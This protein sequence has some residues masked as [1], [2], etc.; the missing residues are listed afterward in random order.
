M[1]SPTLSRCSVNAR[2]LDQCRTGFALLA[3]LLITGLIFG[4]VSAT[5]Q[6]PSPPAPATN[7]SGQ[8]AAEEQDAPAADAKAPADAPPPSDAKEKPA[9]AADSQD[10]QA[11]LDEAMI[12]RIDADTPKQL[13]AVIALL[14]S[15]LVKGLSEESQSFANKMIASIQLERAQALA[16][17]LIQGGGLR[18]RTLRAE[19]LQTLKAAVKSDPELVEA[20]LLIARLHLLP[21]G[22]AE[23]VRKATTKAIELLED[24][25]QAQ[26]G[27]YLLRALRQVDDESRAAD[28]DRAVKTDPANA[29][30][31]QARALLR[32]QNE[33]VTGAVDDLKALLKQDPTNQAVAQVAV[34]E[35]VNMNRTEDALTLLNETLQANPSEGLYRLRGI[36]HRAEGKEDEALADFGKALAMQPKDPVSLLQRAEIS[37]GRGDVQ[38]AKRDL[39]EAIRVEPRVADS[40]AAVRVR[41]YIALE[42]GRIA[43]AIHDMNLIVQAS[44]ED[45]FWT[46]Q[47][48]NLYLQDK[49]PRKAIELVT[50]ILQRDPKNVSALRTRADTLLGLGDHAAAIKDYETALKIGIEEPLQRS[51]VLNNLAWVLA[52]SPKDDLRDG[53]RSIELGTEAAELTDFKEPHILSTLAAGYAEHGDFEEAIKWSS[54]AVQLGREQE[55][56]QIEQLEEEL[57][58]YR[59]NKPWREEQETEENQAP[60]LG[61]DDLIDT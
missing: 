13:E 20:Y 2:N 59:E 31:R 4:T 21:E 1:T 11:D 25:P 49:R 6:E 48:A 42:E 15:A 44:P 34:Q 39:N 40:V 29:E 35:L 17:Q 45:P 57:N 24:N 38:A 53:K 10:G 50:G 43:D 37:L 54:K 8:D 12:R 3:Y 16:A 41:C 30:A 14:E 55:H 60:L 22:D 61:P 56:D 51:G 58:S 26:S 36:I 9:D 23:E 32:L 27:A 19:A 46:L 5:G 33:D 7:A 47:L 52:T 18:A 28:L